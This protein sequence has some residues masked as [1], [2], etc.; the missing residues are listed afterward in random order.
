MSFNL[1]EETRERTFWKPGKNILWRS[2]TLERNPSSEIRNLRLHPINTPNFPQFLTKSNHSKSQFGILDLARASNGCSDVR[3][4]EPAVFD[5][6]AP[7]GDPGRDG[8]GLEQRPQPS[9]RARREG[10]GGDAGRREGTPG[11]VRLRGG[12]AGSEVRRHQRA[13]GGERAGD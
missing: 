10:N 6:A 1:L 9:L 4:G 5:A 13:G 11:E 2:G 7:S 8:E 12:H 3:P